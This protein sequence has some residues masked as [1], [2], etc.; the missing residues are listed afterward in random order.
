MKDSVKFILFADLH[1]KKGM[2]I[3]S[4][5]DVLEVFEEAKRRDA[6]FVIHAGDMCN[7]YCRSPELINT[8]LKNPHEIP[9]YGVYG[10]HELEAEGNSMQVVTPTLTNCPEDVTW[11]SEDGRINDG[12]FAYYYF[13]VQDLRVVCTDTNYS[14]NPNIDIWEHNATA[15]FCSPSKEYNQLRYGE[16]AVANVYTDSLGPRQLTWLEEVLTD[17]A[18]KKKK[19]IVVGHASFNKNWQCSPDTDSVNEIYEKVNRITPNTVIMSIN[20]HYHTNRIEVKNNIVYFDVNTIRNGCWKNNQNEHHYTDEHTMQ[21]A[22]YDEKGELVSVEK[23]PITVLSQAK[24]TW[25]FEKPLSA[26]VTVFPKT[27]KI[28]IEGKKTEW[29]YGVTPD[30]IPSWIS[31]EIL[32]AEF[33]VAPQDHNLSK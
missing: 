29:I 28:L 9:A 16:D 5:D 27:C 24:N 4:L 1:Y 7:D 12:E 14:Y 19:V 13:D 18:N 2:Y 6:D 26:T 11:G 10:N 30:D 25:F 22:R 15:S 20:G 3:A 23:L 32:S 8:W 17:A 21:A 33:C 31:P